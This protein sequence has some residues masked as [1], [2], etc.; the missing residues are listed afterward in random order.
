MK[1]TNREPR[2]TSL[3]E[4]CVSIYQVVAGAELRGPISE[5]AGVVWKPTLREQ[6]WVQL[7]E[8][9]EE[10]RKAMK[11]GDWGVAVGVGPDGTE[12]RAHVWHHRCAAPRLTSGPRPVFSVGAR[13]T[14]RLH[15]RQWTSPFT[16]LSLPRLP[17]ILSL[18]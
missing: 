6:D 4:Q 13:D 16:S 14:S 17:L 18:D 7:G 8:V 10:L 2:N 5:P 15:A 11:E 9:S 3:G 1:V 12:Y